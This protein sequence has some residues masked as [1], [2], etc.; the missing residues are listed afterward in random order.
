M[1]GTCSTGEFRVLRRPNYSVHP[2]GKGQGRRPEAHRPKSERTTIRA[3]ESRPRADQGGALIQ[4]RW[5]AQRSLGQRPIKT[6]YFDTIS[7][8]HDAM[9]EGWR[10]LVLIGCLGGSD[11]LAVG[12]LQPAGPGVSLPASGLVLCFM[13]SLQQKV[14]RLYPMY[15]TGGLQPMPSTEEFHAMPN[16]A[17]RYIAGPPSWPVPPIVQDFGPSQILSWIRPTLVIAKFPIYAPIP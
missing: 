9:D 12:L 2:V 11:S 13:Q 15:P 10:D 7:S 14:P 16:L 3:S 17:E 6:H 1:N 4:T 5:I 8:V